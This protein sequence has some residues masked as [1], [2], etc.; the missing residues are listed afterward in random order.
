[1][2]VDTSKYPAVQGKNL[3]LFARKLSEAKTKRGMPVPYQ[4]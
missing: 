4:T 3:I 1:M 2:A